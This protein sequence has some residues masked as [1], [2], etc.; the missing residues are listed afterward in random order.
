MFFKT[1]AAAAAVLAVGVAADGR[2]SN[3]SICDYYTTALLM[4]NTAANQMTLLTLVVNTAVIGNYTKPNVGISV[5]GILAKG[6]YN[7]TAVNLAPYFNG[8]LAST[9]TGGSV[10][11]SVNFLDGGGAAPLMK[12]MP[13]MDNTSNQYTLITHLYEYFGVLLGC[14]MQGGGDYPGYTGHE[15]MYTVHKF[16][17]L[18]AAE[19][20]YFIQQVAMSAASFGVAQDDLTVVGKALSSTFDVKCAPPTAVIMS[21]GPQLQSICIDET[22][23]L[24]VNSTCDMYNGTTVKPTVANATLAG[25]TTASSTASSTTKPSSSSTSVSK[26]GAVAVGMSFAAVFGGLAA[27]FL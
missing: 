10:G 12:N 18:S 20:G 5:P 2:P 21:Q 27:L 1:V 17:D 7:G 15:S 9:N 14:S 13:A 3:T 6:T 25:N 23:A 26:S 4:N 24:A 8:G 16:M 22:C 19:V 11:R